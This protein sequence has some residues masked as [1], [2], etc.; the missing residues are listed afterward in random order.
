MVEPKVADG[1]REVVLGRSGLGKTIS[2]S[3]F[4]QGEGGVLI[5]GGVHGD[6]P[7]GAGVAAELSDY[8]KAR[9][10]AIAGRPVAI[11]TRANPDGL[12]KGRRTNASG[13]DINRN[14]PAS[15][16]RATGAGRHNGGESAASE[17]ETAAIIKAV[18]TLNPRLI[19]ALHAIGRGSHCNNYDGP[20]LAVARLMAKFNGYPVKATMG[21]P[22]PGSFGSWAGIDRKIAVITLEMP[23]DLSSEECWKANRDALLAAIAG[24]REEK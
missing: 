8:I 14:F 19:I 4:G 17:P 16:Y 9:P 1:P 11:I 24:P 23:A 20:G 5:I 22:T 15:N 2:M 13:V 21:Y 3:V 7:S 6:E 10:Q 18:D 12:A